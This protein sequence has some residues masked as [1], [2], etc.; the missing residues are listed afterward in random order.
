MLHAIKYGGGWKISSMALSIWSAKNI[1]LF[2]FQALFLD[3]RLGTHASTKSRD[4]NDIHGDLKADFT[5][6][7][8]SKAL[9]SKGFFNQDLNSKSNITFKEYKG[10]F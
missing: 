6:Y 4:V 5:R 1:G 2:S 10:P 3:T 9:W 7:E 8:F